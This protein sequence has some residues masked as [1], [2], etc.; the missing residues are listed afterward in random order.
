MHK[1][2]VQLSFAIAGGSRPI[3]RQRL[4]QSLERAGFAF[5]FEILFAEAS[6]GEPVCA[7]RNR[8]YRQARGRYVYFL[9]EDCE[10][11][12]AKPTHALPELMASGDAF[13]GPYG[14]G[15][16]SRL[17][18]RIYNRMTHTWVS[19]HARLGSP[20][21]LAGNC[22]IPKS[23]GLDSPYGQFARFGGEEVALQS[24]LRSS[25]ITLHY[26]E[27]LRIDHNAQ[28]SALSFLSRAW[29]H[30]RSPAVARS[31]RL[32]PWAARWPSRNPLILAA[33]STYAATQIL[34][35]WWARA[36]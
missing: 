18:G 7:L 6:T 25:G 9:D 17:F 33:L 31:R 8:L 29:L 19:T 3:L 11:P 16:S 21:P 1:N 30:G 23:G 22:L 26:R 24:W 27:S 2:N 28:H 12:V 35:R 20:V 10:W 4:V 13:T 15:S 14:D 32:R 34:S 5:Q 36:W